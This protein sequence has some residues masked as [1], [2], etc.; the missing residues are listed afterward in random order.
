MKALQTA[1]NKGAAARHAG[2]PA[3]A[4]PYKDNRQATG[5][6][7]FSRAFRNAWFDGYKKGTPT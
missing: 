7:T 1:F 3:T 6:L 4:C 5:R 2:L